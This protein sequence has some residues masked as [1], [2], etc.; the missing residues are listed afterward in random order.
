MKAKVLAAV[1]VASAIAPIHT[2][3]AGPLDQASFLAKVVKAKLID[4]GR[5][6]KRKAVCK[7]LPCLGNIKF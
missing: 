2:A 1:L 3:Q 4:G 5:G 7:L 6:L